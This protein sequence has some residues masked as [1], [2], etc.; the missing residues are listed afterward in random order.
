MIRRTIII[1]A[2]LFV[3]FGIYAQE[4]KSQNNPIFHKKSPTGNIKGKVTE[5]GRAHV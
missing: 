1:A 5:I 4:I 2:S 3:T